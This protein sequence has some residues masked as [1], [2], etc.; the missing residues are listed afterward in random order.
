MM[1]IYEVIDFNRCEYSDKNGSYGGLAGNKD[2]LLFDGYEWMVKYPKNLSQFR[3]QNASYSTS[4]LSEFLGSHI[5]QLL[6]FDTHDTLLGERNGK[7]VCACKDFAPAFEKRLLEIRTLKNHTD[8]ELDDLLEQLE[9]SSTDTHVEDLDELLLHINQNPILEKVAGVKQRFFEQA[10]IDIF[11][12]N[13]DRNSGNWGIIREPGK[14]DTLAPVYDNGG[15]FSTNVSEEKMARILS[16]DILENNVLNVLTA[17][18]K[19]GH[20]YSAKKFMSVVGEIPEY[21]SAVLRVVP[22]IN[23]NLKAIHRL[24]DIIP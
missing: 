18:G 10:V 22:L 16:G 14:K 19:N 17:Y 7:I 5:Y 4:P 3:G 24:I 13:S 15:S 8:D 11:L 1:D 21:R 12:N 9:D 2:G 20:L 23:T 6:G